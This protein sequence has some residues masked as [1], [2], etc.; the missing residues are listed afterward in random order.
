MQL[1]NLIPHLMDERQAI[2]KVLNFLIILASI[3]LIINISVTTFHYETFLI[4]SINSDIQLAICLFFCFSFFVFFLLS[5]NKKKFLVKYFIIL[6]LSIPYTTILNYVSIPLTVQQ[7]YLISFIPLLRGGVAL[8]MLILLVVK[9][10]STALLV[11]YIVFL[12][13]AVYSTSMIFFIFERSVNIQVETYPDA[14]WWAAMTVTTN[15]SNIIPLTVVGKVVTTL[16]AATG[17]TA[18][19]VFTVYFTSIMTRISESKKVI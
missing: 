3:F 8:V 19:P 12:C 18:F 2:I 10:N 11:S 4:Q 16:L 5:E 7:I 1:K 13:A 14:L 6:L 17:M 9:R 15:G